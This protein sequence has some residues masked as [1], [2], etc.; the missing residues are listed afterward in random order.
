MNYL[1]GVGNIVAVV[2]E[3]MDYTS[4]TAF[5]S[6]SPLKSPSKWAKKIE[7]PLK[8]FKSAVHLTGK[9]LMACHEAIKNMVSSEK[10][11]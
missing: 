7:Q 6:K 2:L 11:S 8:N 4:T 5:I 1:S 9:V 3:C 10:E